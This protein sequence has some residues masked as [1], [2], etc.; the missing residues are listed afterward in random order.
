MRIC[1]VAHSAAKGGAE[2][3][4]LET[5]K[6]LREKGHKC[7]VILPR[8]GPLIAELEAIGVNSYVIPYRWM[9]IGRGKPLKRALKK[10]LLFI[11]NT[12]MLVPVAIT[13]KRHKCDIVYTNTITI[14][15]GAITAKFL[16]LPH[17]WHLR[18]FGE[19]DHGLKFILGERL[20]YAIMKKCTSAFIANSKAVAHKYKNHVNKDIYVIY[21][22][23]CIED[24]QQ[25]IEGIGFDEKR[26]KRNLNCTIVG[27]LSEGKRQDEAIRAIGEVVKKGITVNLYIVGDGPVVYKDYLNHLITE[28]GLKNFITFTGRV[29]NIG[30]IMREIDILLMCSRNEAFGRVTIEAMRYGKP[31]IGSRSGGTT[32]LIRDGFN[33]FLYEPGDYKSLANLIT[34]FYHNPNLLK[35]MGENGKLWVEKNFT[36]EKFGNQLTDVLNSVV[37]RNQYYANQRT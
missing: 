4:L 34:L 33:G 11:L 37:Y 14:F 24:T 28:L 7:Y 1:F 36:I 6:A 22:P 27:T 13:I 26:N 23:V 21:N 17:I 32:E 18:E 35:K 31:V 9:V 3:S 15:V 20:S 16:K 8:K 29:E 19:E 10:I 30:L 25:K 5:I 12:I 2:R